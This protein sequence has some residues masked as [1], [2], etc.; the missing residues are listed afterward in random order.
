M[1]RFYS[2]AEAVRAEIDDAMFRELGMPERS[3]RAEMLHLV[4]VPEPGAIPIIRDGYLWF[5]AAADSTRIIQ[6]DMVGPIEPMFK[7]MH[8]RA[9]NTPSNEQ[10][11][12]VAGEVGFIKIGKSK[13]PQKRLSGL[14]TGSPIPLTIIALADGGALREAAYHMQFEGHRRHG[15]WFDRHPDILREIERLAR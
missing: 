2:D 14:Q 11:Y 15:E 9:D 5:W 6:P 3:V 1:R 8:R 10:C 7:Q 12:F 4:P 13:E